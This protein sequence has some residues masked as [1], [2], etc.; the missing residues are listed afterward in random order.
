MSS[1]IMVRDLTPAVIWSFSKTS[2]TVQ[3]KSKGAK[4]RTGTYIY[5]NHRKQKNQYTYLNY[6]QTS[7]ETRFISQAGLSYFVQIKFS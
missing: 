5:I 1:E 4:N 2:Y 3:T 6:Q 7:A